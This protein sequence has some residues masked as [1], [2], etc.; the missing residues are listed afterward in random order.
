MRAR[1][2]KPAF[3]KNDELSELTIT[4]RL[5]FIGLWCYADRDGLFEER[6]KKIKAEIFPYD[7]LK[8]EH[9]TQALA[10]LVTSGFLIVFHNS[11]GNDIMQIVNFKKH[12][13]PH[14]NEK[15][16]VLK[17]IIK[18]CDQGSNNLLPKEVPLP[19]DIRNEELGTM[20]D[21]IRND[22]SRDR[23]F[24]LWCSRDFDLFWKEYPKKVG[25]KKKAKESFINKC[26]ESKLSGGFITLL[27]NAVKLQKRSKQWKK[28]KGEFIPH[29]T[30]WLNGKRWNDEVVVEETLAEKSA[31]LTSELAKE[32]GNGDIFG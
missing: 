31:R 9:I 7:N 22:D 20:N 5:L 25:D 16:S 29:P 23:D 15:P 13:S 11:N 30:T 4:A 10:A 24:N 21:D 19:P 2:I 6:P 32:D 27:L 3:F 1:N 28:D 14:H 26:K 18:T 12:Q 8:V 17:D